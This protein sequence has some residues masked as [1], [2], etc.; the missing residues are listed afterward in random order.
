MSGLDLVRKLEGEL[1]RL[2]HV[3][4]ALAGVVNSGSCKLAANPKHVE[5]WIA[6]WV[7]WDRHYNRFQ[8]S[9]SLLHSALFHH[10]GGVCCRRCS[11]LDRPTQ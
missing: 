11:P 2:A 4:L 6:E 3:D 7:Q 9:R 8:H 1:K 5:A 10:L